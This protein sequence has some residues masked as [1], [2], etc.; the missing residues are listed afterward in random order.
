MSSEK[1][2]CGV[3]GGDVCSET[4]TKLIFCEHHYDCLI[5][6]QYNKNFTTP[7]NRCGWGKTSEP[8]SRCMAPQSK[9][10]GNF[11]KVH[12]DRY[13]SD[14]FSAPKGTCFIMHTVPAG[15]IEINLPK[16]NDPELKHFIENLRK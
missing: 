3:S 2:N 14:P 13:K 5:A 4:Q 9:G 16:S 6:S 8:F 10:C 12:H 15:T 7:P 11:C 1:Q